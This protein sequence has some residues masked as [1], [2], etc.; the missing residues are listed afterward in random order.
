MYLKLRRFAHRRIEKQYKNSLSNENNAASDL[1]K[2]VIMLEKQI[3]LQIGMF[4]P[5]SYRI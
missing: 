5:N 2:P 3:L 1:L 4:L